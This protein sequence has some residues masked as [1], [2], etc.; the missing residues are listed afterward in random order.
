M[1]GEQAIQRELISPWVVRHGRL[2][3]AKVSFEEGREHQ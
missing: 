1:P 3:M 2:A